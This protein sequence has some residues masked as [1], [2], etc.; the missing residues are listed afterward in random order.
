MEIE[1]AIKH[2]ELML[3]LR[4]R[5]KE[6]FPGCINYDKD[7]DAIEIVLNVLEDAKNERD[8]YKGY[9][10]STYKR[11]RHLIKSKFIE[12]YDQFDFKKRRLQIRYTR[13]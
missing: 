1:E 3:K 6:D 2:L 7:I 12:K 11:F 4:K 9:Y 13:S 5:N 10:E 8:E